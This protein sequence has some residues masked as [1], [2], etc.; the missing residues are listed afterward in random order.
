MP[1]SLKELRPSDR[2]VNTAAFLVPGLRPGVVRGL[3]V[4]H[5]QAQSWLRPS[6]NALDFD[7]RH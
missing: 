1:Y 6:G 3:G 5:S 2:A 4:F 7:R